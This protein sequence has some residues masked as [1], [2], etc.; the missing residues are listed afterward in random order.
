MELAQ[1]IPALSD[2]AAYP[3]PGGPV[4]VRQTHI[5]VV[6]LAGAWVYK[7]KKPVDLGFLDFSTLEKRHHFCHEEVRLNRRLAP[8]VYLGVVAVAQR[9]RGLRLE[10]EGEPV[11][12]AV[13]MRRLSEESTLQKRLLRGA[14]DAAA[15]ELVA[16]RLAAFH[17]AAE[18]GPQIA[19]FGGFAVVAGNARENLA[20][21]AAQVGDT[22]SAPV[23]ERLHGLLEQ[24]LAELRP[25]I[26]V[27]AARGVPC[28]THGDLHLDHVY[29][30]PE[31][32]PP[33]DL[34]IIDCVEFNERFRYADPVADMAFLAMDLRFHGRPDLAQTFS[35][36]Y[37]AA[38]R[39]VEGAGLLPFYAAYRAAVRGKVEGLELAEREVP[40]DERRAARSR[41]RA[42]W[43]LALG[44]LERP[45]RRPALVLL[46]G[47]PGAGKSTLARSLAEQA[48][49]VVIRSDEVRKELAGN[50]KIVG[51]PGTRP[52]TGERPLTGVVEDI[53]TP[54]WSQRTYA[55]CARRAEAELF[56]G[57]RVLV[58]ANFRA[59][60][61]RRVFL[62]LARDWGVPG[63][64]LVCRADPATARR[65][66]AGRHGDVSDADWAVY[67]QAARE[68]QEPGPATRPFARELDANGAAE[69]T[70]ARALELLRGDGL[71]PGG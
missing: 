31:R 70:L 24:A 4:D 21:A 16:R 35:S 56:A 32:P 17:A 26:E 66:L 44:Q 27:R 50:P 20:Q 71:L 13:K 23:C 36:A 37:F 48:G 47:L 22:L 2:P 18:R 69:Q 54:P 29:L 57:G 61:Q 45:E 15:L 52:S 63:L 12:W 25:V 41:A 1:L 46:A 10:G 53:Y 7:V 42:H 9:S 34:V 40:Q 5:S 3:A 39:D 33:G 11:E 58:D 14:L 55:E 60:E 62:D 19:P 64:L 38:A 43:L 49:F 67:Q 8:D 51:P 30:F 59:E 68:W 65:R 28:D 6:F